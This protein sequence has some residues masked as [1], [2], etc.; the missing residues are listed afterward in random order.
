MLDTSV[1]LYGCA[2]KNLWIRVPA[3]VYAAH[4]ATTLVPIM[5]HVLFYDFSDGN[6]PGPSTM[7]ERLT[8]LAVY[9]PYLIIPLAIMLRLLFGKEHL[10]GKKQK[11]T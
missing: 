7:K 8:L 10:V 6:F 11:A 1:N 5:G 2:E 4:V 9:S 3:L